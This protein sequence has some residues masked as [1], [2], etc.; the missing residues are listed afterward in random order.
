M[1]PWDVLSSVERLRECFV[2]PLGS[3]PT[4]GMRLED[5]QESAVSGF[6]A[7]PSE[8]SVTPMT[9]S[10][11]WIESAMTVTFRAPP[12]GA[13]PYTVE[14]IAAWHGDSLVFVLA[15]NSPWAISPATGDCV[16]E[17]RLTCFDGRV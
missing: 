5:L 3:T 6:E 16:F 1:T 4:P 2:A 9:E 15:P 7:T 17:V 12:P 11:G 8:V 14:G 10:P 13:P